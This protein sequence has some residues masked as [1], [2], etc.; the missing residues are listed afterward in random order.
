MEEDLQWYVV[1]TQ[2]KRE[3]LA[4]DHLRLL[5]GVEVFCPML[6]YRKAT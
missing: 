3:R 5:D 2:T 1:R 6:R 4:A